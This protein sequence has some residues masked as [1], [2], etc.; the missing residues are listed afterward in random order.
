MW[1]ERNRG[2]CRV[3]TFR[4][5]QAS[6]MRAS[7]KSLE[8]IK[9]RLRPVL[10]RHGVSKAVVFGSW[11]RGDV[12]RRSD[13]DLL[14]VQETTKRFLER[15]DGLLY[16][17]AQAVPGMD[18]DVFVYTPEELERLADRPLIANALREGR[19]VL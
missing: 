8:D 10:E 2:N 18:L 6:G 19:V 13:L 7:L 16:E 11:A 5:Q 9:D 4:S 14:L 3:R 17:L 15:Y 1:Q 12:S